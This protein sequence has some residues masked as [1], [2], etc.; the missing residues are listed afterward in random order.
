M[1]DVD[2]IVVPDLVADIA[3]HLLGD[4]AFVR[5]F[6]ME[7]L[8]QSVTTVAQ[9]ILSSDRSFVRHGSSRFLTPTALAA[10]MASPENGDDEALTDDE[11]TGRKTW[12]FNFT[13]FVPAREAVIRLGEMTRIDLL[14][15][16]AWRTEK[17][18]GELRMAAL[19]EQLAKP[20]ADGQAVRDHWADE[21]I[22]RTYERLDGKAAPI[23]LRSVK[24][25]ARD[26][27]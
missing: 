20:L 3:S 12:L 19:F 4:D 16:A 13:Q 22:A 10:V 1:T 8:R 26:A 11:R 14:G 2:E 17:G 25:V 23:R 27:A 5:Q 6:A 24:E 15:A 21:D 18:R 9:T 7:H